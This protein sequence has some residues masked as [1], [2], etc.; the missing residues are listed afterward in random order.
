MSDLGGAYAEA[1]ATLSQELSRG[2]RPIEPR[3][4]HW[5]DLQT[6]ATA[7]PPQLIVT[8]GASALRGLIELG[9]QDP[10]IAR[11]PVLAALLPKA[12][13]DNLASR[14]RQPTSAVLLDQPV[15]RYLDLVRLAMPGNRR[16]GVLLGPESSILAPQLARAAAVRGL[17]VVPIQISGEP[18]ELYPALRTLLAE[19]DVLLALPDGQVYNAASLQTVL[20]TTYRQR[21]P[22]VAFS[23]AY[24]KAGATL[25]LYTAPAQAASQTATVVKG[26]LA[27]RGLPPPQLA[28]DFSVAK[29]ERVARSLGVADGESDSLE[30]SLKRQEVA[31]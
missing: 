27:G 14:A 22:V 13:Y 8:L 18:T 19:S 11:V 28:S 15:G 21:V 25:A 9:Q 6:P 23:A 2:P 20:I 4:I 26:F 7:K 10:T 3:V 16:V 1:A 24:A 17:Q 31:R 29:N 12:S 30:E 5:R